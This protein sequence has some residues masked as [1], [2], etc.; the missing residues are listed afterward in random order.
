MT[1]ENQDFR[2]EQEPQAYLAHQDQW[3]LQEIEDLLEKM[4]Q[5]DLGVHPDHRGAQGLQESQD[6]VGNQESPETMADQVHLD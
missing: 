1:Q 4:V 5:W 6:P 2:A 3:D